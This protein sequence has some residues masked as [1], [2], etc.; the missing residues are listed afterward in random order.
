MRFGYLCSYVYVCM[1]VGLFANLT[2]GGE[3]E[4]SG[5]SGCLVAFGSE[6]LGLYG[7]TNKVSRTQKFLNSL[8]RKSEAAVSD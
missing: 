6:G 5:F 1:T 8:H 3:V 2:V 4:G 7:V